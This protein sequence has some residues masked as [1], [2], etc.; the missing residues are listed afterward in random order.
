MEWRGIL[1][2][3]VFCGLV[4]LLA[5]SAEADNSAK[6]F[7]AS[8]IDRKDLREF[9]S[10]ICHEPIDDEF[11][12]DL[13]DDGRPERLMGVTCGNGG[14]QYNCF[15][16]LG[17]ER[18]KFIGS[19]FINRRGF[20]VLRT[21]HGGVHDILGYWHTSAESGSLT[22]YEFDGEKYGVKKRIDNV[23]PS[24]FELLRPTKAQ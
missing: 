23:S 2:T 20:E 12:V 4:M 14:C 7:D 18:F 15:M 17:E 9:V 3:W 16:N 5:I 22:R 10:S 1:N 21:K 8:N 6:Q 19:L 13:N 24:F 11:E